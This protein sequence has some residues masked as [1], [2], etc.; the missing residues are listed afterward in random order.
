MHDTEFGADSPLDATFDRLDEIISLTFDGEVEPGAISEL[1][2]LLAASS[3]AR[4]RYV[5]AAWLHADLKLFFGQG[6]L[7]A[8][9]DSA[10]GGLETTGDPSA[11][12]VVALPWE[13]GLTST[14]DA[15]AS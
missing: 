14:P 1:E 13:S 12:A 3:D 2:D 6:L 15:N 11:A 8:G 10:S 4:T 5:E 9:A 7:G